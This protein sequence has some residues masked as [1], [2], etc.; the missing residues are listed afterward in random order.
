MDGKLGDQKGSGSV[1]VYWEGSGQD[2]GSG[3]GVLIK[4]VDLQDS[5]SVG[6]CRPRS[7]IVKHCVGR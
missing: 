7:R 1:R 6:P 3:N 5:T 4:M 2:K